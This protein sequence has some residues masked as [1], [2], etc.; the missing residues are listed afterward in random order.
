MITDKQDEE[1]LSFGYYE[2]TTTANASTTDSA[3]LYN[4]NFFYRTYVEVKSGQYLKFSNCK[5]YKTADYAAVD[6]DAESWHSGQY[7]VGTDLYPGEYKLTALSND[8]FLSNGYV[9]IT[10][11]PNG[12]IGTDDFVSNDLIENQIY[13]TLES[14]DYIEFSKAILTKIS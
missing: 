12:E 3:F 1:V 5:L 8:S 10:R 13:V 4:G 2:V 6:K 11:T 14:G 7:K 9:A